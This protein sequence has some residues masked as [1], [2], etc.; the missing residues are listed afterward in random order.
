MDHQQDVNAQVPHINRV[1]VKIPPFWDADPQLWFI[2]V[3]TQFAL[4]QI[5]ADDTKYNYV[6]SSLDKKYWAEVR[7]ILSNPPPT[8]KYEK[9]KSELIRRLSVTQDQKTRRLLEHEEM[10]GTVIPDDVLRPLWCDRLPTFTQAILASQKQKTLD[11]LADL[12]EAVADA[13]P[14]GRVE[15]TGVVLVCY[16]YRRCYNR[17]RP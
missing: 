5:T 8:G 6:V 16:P 17:W 11:E 3:E 2:N 15:E 4:G 9:L 10:A 13:N 12:A 7:D 14:R 1:A